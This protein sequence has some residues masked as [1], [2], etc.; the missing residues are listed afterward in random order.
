M[1]GES[2]TALI[3]IRTSI[4]AL[5]AITPLSFVY[6][7][8]LLISPIF[9][10]TLPCLNLD[11]FR[12]TSSSLLVWILRV[13]T[14]NEVWFYFWSQAKTVKYQKVGTLDSLLA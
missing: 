11:I 10:F 14:G 4:L 9:Q 2:T 8:L 13:V 5:R 1:I 3:F 12:W 7:A 6:W